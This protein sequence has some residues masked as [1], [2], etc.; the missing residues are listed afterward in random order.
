M[1]QMDVYV[2][3]EKISD[4][5]WNLVSGWDEFPRRTVGAQLVRSADSIGANLMEGDGRS[6]TPDSLNFF[7]IA[8][9]SC[10]ETIHFLRRAR[11]RQLLEDETAERLTIDLQRAGQMHNKLI[12]YRRLL[13]ASKKVI[14][15]TRVAYGDSDTT[16]PVV[17]AGLDDF[18]N[19]D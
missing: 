6:T 19:N 2:R 13:L 18:P 8:R 4:E 17:L 15:E 9:G 3:F 1:E 16:H 12:S 11:A 7:Y 10:K 14:R 5:I